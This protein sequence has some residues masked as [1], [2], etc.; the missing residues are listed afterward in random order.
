MSTKR[1]N[2]PEDRPRNF[3]SA[4]GQHSSRAAAVHPDPTPSAPPGTVTLPGVASL[5]CS[6][7]GAPMTATAHT[8]ATAG[9]HR[10]WIDGEHREEW[11][12]WRCEDAGENYHRQAAAILRLAEESP[13]E[14]LDVML[15]EEAGRLVT[16]RE[17]TKEGWK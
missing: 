5:T 16:A 4:L 14:V 10:A 9:G 6:V 11:L 2:H 8:T 1:T 12:Y 13:S 7:C 15:R 3:L 17:A